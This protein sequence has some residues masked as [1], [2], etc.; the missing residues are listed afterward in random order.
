MAPETFATLLEHIEA[1]D[2]LKTSIKAAGTSWRV[3]SLYMAQDVAAASRYARARTVSADFYADKAQ[4]AVEAATDKDDAVVAKIQADVYRWRA[5]VANPRVYGD[6][7]DV[8][9]KGELVIR[10]E[11]VAMPL[12]TATLTEVLT[13]HLLS[14]GDFTQRITDTAHEVTHAK[15]KGEHSLDD[16]A[17]RN[18]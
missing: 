12:P 8:E 17:S 13:P 4:Q 5:G 16:D 15:D 3:L 14:S 11:R 10:V 1:G 7:L 6:K 18:A 2:T 9:S